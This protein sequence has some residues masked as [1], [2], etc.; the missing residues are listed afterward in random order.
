MLQGAGRGPP[1]RRRLRRGVRRG[2][3][4]RRRPPSTTAGRGAVLRAATAAPASGW[5]SVRPPASPTPPTSPRTGC[6]RGRGRR[7]PL[8]GGAAPR[9]TSP[10]R[11]RPPG[12]RPHP[13]PSPRPQGRAAAPGR[14]GRP[15]RG[16]RSPRSATYADSRRRILVA[17]S[18]GLLAEDDQVS[19][20]FTVG[21]VATATPG[22]RPAGESVGH[23]DR[24]RAV[25][26]LRR[27]GAGP[28]GR[29][30]G[31]HQAVAR[32]RPAAR[33]RS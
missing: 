11:P 33:C 28:R 27:R 5:S 16:S 29:R 26:P 2:Q 20:L 1:A 6:V 13:R 10:A 21:N 9:S 17:N 30:P 8:G 22:C 19:T 15:G 24:L 4:R 25:R 31:G 23:T 7:P 32:P 14:R 18:D 3:A 12:R